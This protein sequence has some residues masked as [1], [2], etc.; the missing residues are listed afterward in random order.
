MA[1]SRG[2]YR[3]LLL[4]GI[5]KFI[6]ETGQERPTEYTEVFNTP[7]M[8]TNPIKDQQMTGLGAIGSMPEGTNFPL[9]D[10]QL[11]PTMTAEAV[12]Y[13]GAFE[14]TRPMYE[15]E[16][17]GAINGMAR[18]LGRGARYRKEIDAFSL[19]NNGFNSSFPG[20]DGLPLFSTAHVSFGDGGVTQA[21]RPNPDI[22]FSQTAIQNAL[23]A[24]YSLKNERGLPELLSPSMFVIGASNVFAAREILGSGHKAYTADN[25]INALAP[26]NLSYMVTQFLTTQTNW[27]ALAANHDLNFFVRSDTT[28][29]SFDDPWTMNAVYTVWQRHVPYF[30]RWK[31][32]FGSTG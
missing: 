25:E 3:T 9:D 12:P 2:P 29:D 20:F 17:Y 24:F 10:F 21:N 6:I 14:V 8:E 7:P 32:T 30:G 26:E 5:R 19:F 31:G 28:T 13:G 11:G 16:L 4:P 1:I 27:F 22:G 15:D 18:E 23:I